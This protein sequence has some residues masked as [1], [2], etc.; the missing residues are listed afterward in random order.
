MNLSKDS[1]IPKIE[2]IAMNENSKVFIEEALSIPGTSYIKVISEASTMK[3][4]KINFELNG[5]STEDDEKPGD[6]EKP[7]DNDLDE[8][9]KPE[10]SEGLPNTGQSVINFA[11]IGIISSLAGVKL[12]RRKN[13]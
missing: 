4:Y 13:K 7:N 5:N 11:I 2:A 12:L 8:N 10:D 1:H 6:V 9:N 3:T